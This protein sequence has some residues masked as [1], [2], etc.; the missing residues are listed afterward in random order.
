MSTCVKEELKLFDVEFGIFII[1]GLVVGYLPQIIKLFRKKNSYGISPLNRLIC[2]VSQTFLVSNVFLL[3][4]NVI[5]CSIKEKY[6]I[7]YVLGILLGLI[8]VLVQWI[9]VAMICFLFVVYYPRYNQDSKVD[10]KIK[11]RRIKEWKTTVISIYIFTVS[12]IILVGFSL[13]ATIFE[14][15]INIIDNIAAIFGLAS[16]F[17]A[18]FQYLPQIIKT[19]VDKDPGAVSILTLSIQVPGSLVM[20]LCL[21]IQP[22]TNWTSSTSY[23][24]GFLLEGTILVLCIYY[25]LKNRRRDK[26]NK[27]KNDM[28]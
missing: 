9:C 27:E 7:L 6:D 19:Y 21:I 11:N 14:W 5:R 12:F 4:R 23:F 8:Q 10:E 22:G 15:N 25:T 16:A 18:I 17:L 20:A 1:L 13:L 26:K 24:V 2:I 3:Q 28:V